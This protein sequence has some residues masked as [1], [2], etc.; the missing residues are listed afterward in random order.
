MWWLIALA[1]PR[2]EGESEEENRA[3]ACLLKVR[4]PRSVIESEPRIGIRSRR[5]GLGLP[6]LWRTA[7]AGQCRL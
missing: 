7:S 3:D 6:R 2:I 5:A 1:G 4:K